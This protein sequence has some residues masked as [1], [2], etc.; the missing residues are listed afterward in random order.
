MDPY[1]NDI[2]NPKITSNVEFHNRYNIIIP[3]LL[4][5]DQIIIIT[6]IIKKK[7]SKH[8]KNFTKRFR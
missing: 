8:I 2:L 3:V 6:D 4:L 1:I 5:D 7:H